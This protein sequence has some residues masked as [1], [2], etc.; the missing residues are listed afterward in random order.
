[1]KTDNGTPIDVTL[2]SEES[3][4]QR[5]GLP[6]PK[7]RPEPPPV[8]ARTPKAPV[9]PMEGD[10]V[11][12]RYRI[13]P[14]IGAGGMGIV[15]RATHVE[16]ETTVALKVI[17]PD[18]AQSSSIWRRFSREARALGALQNRHVVRVSDAGTLSSGL[19]Y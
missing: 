11:A 10:L 1:M 2:V 18:L 12:E 7:P 6:P 13:G 3:H 8:R 9:T 14:V 17:R 15:Y 5:E 16:L 19:R 4:D